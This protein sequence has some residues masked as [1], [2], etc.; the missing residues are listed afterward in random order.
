MEHLLILLNL[1]RLFNLHIPNVTM[2]RK[3]GWKFLVYLIKEIDTGIKFFI[4]PLL[5]GILF[6]F[7]WSLDYPGVPELA[8]KGPPWWCKIPL[9][10]G[11]KRKH[12]SLIF[13][14]KQKIL[15]IFQL[16][17]TFIWKIVYYSSISC[18]AHHLFL[19]YFFILFLCL[20][21]L[22]HVPKTFNPKI[23]DLRAKGSNGIY[24]SRPSH[25]NLIWS[26]RPIFIL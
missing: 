12:F 1:H 11:K 26:T 18:P 24:T 23:T 25:W 21:L 6:F 2:D 19:V 3:L 10:R 15:W 16:Y 8:V 22:L 13:Y 5:I 14:A 4:L 7:L 17:I 9:R 20:F